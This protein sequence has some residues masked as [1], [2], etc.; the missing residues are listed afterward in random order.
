MLKL[1]VV[2][3]GP[4]SEPTKNVIENLRQCDWLNN[5]I[6]SSYTNTV[7]VDLD[8][9]I[10]IDNELLPNSGIGNRNLQIN[11]S[12]NGLTKVQTKYCAKM[13]TDQIISVKSLNDMYRF[14]IDNDDPENRVVESNKPHGRVYVCGLYKR[15]PY[16]PRDHVFWGFSDDVKALC[17]V[18]F[19]TNPNMGNPDYNLYTR[20]ETYIGQ[21]YY[22][23][24]NPQIWNHIQNPTEFLT[25]SAPRLSEAMQAD[26]DLRDTLFKVFPRIELAWP[27]HGLETYHYHVGAMCSE[28]W[29][30]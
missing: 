17:D 18:P 7:N 20:A 19:D 27:K 9:I 30:D 5:I 28:Y 24:Y 12:K 21:Y 25:D 6:L 13:R 3:Q 15:F 8:K 14:W 23:I 16:H 1:D 26:W 22:A 10:Y 11:T 4:C 2:L 29:A